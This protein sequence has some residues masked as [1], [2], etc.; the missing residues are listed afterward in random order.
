ME[1]SS[2]HRLINL[3]QI[4]VTVFSFLSC[5]AEEALIT[6]IEKEG[7]IETIQK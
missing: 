3:A 1:A 4:K 2:S 7:E 5:W 6:L